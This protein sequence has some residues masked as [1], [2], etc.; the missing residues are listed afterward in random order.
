MRFSDKSI[1]FKGQSACSYAISACKLTI[2]SMI[3]G[4]QTRCFKSE[5]SI[6][7]AKLSPFCILVAY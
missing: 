7:L 2:K 1:A 5:K 3:I 6:F 4:Q